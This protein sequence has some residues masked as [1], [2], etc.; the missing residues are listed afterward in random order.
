MS[1]SSDFLFKIQMDGKKFSADTRI[2]SWITRLIFYWV[3]T[4]SADIWIREIIAGQNR[5]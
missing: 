3:L 1:I 5:L 4:F 2:I